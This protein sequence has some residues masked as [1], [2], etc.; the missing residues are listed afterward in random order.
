M[1]IDWHR[2]GEIFLTHFHPDH[3]ADLVPFLFATRNPTALRA[4]E[5]F[6]LTGAQGL[7]GFLSSLRD[8]YRGWLELPPGLLQVT[9][10][11]NREPDR[12]SYP[13]FWV[14]SAPLVH[15]PHSLGY[16]IEFPSGKSLVYS[17]DTGFCEAIVELARDA[18]LL[19]LESSFPDSAPVE[20][21]LTPSLAGKIAAQSGARRLVLLHFYPEVL[22]TDIAAQCRRTY[23]GP[24]TVG[25]D[26][27]HIRL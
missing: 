20:G 27:L 9:E 12:R 23:S 6:G 24:L 1:G 26:F 13:D 21:H 11:R 16:R 4:R 17:G 14:R 10:L 5:P 25:R 7:Q 2:I 22:R 15:T 19:I 3:M 18:D 8:T